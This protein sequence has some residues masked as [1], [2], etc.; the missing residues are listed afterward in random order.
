VIVYGRSDATL[1]PGGVR[2]GTAEIYRI[3]EGLPEIA[4]SVVVGK[5][6]PDEDVAVC[7]FVVLRPG[8]TLTTELAKKIRA[9]I[10]EGATRRHVPKHIKQVSA[11]P[12]TIS[13]KKVE[14]AIRQVIH[15]RDVPNRDALANPGVLNEYS[16][17]V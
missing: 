12:Y 16:G 3:V 2:I 14:M 10:A 6:T 5:D 13:G 4:D 7:L 9:A 8:L 11:I 1:N 15:G 17:L